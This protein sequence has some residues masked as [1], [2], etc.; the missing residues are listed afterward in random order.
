M[1]SPDPPSTAVAIAVA[2][3]PASPPTAPARPTETLPALEVARL[4]SVIVP[5]AWL[6]IVSSPAPPL[7]P[8]AAAT[9]AHSALE[10]P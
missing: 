9:E 4:V 10:S 7:M 2:E 6:M 5:T 1:S 8:V 3:V